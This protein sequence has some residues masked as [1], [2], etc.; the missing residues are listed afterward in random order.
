[1]SKR[2]FLTESEADL[3]IAAAGQVGR[4]GHRD[5]TMLLMTYTHGLRVSELCST[6]WSQIDLNAGNIYVDRIKG[7][8]P[9][10]QPLRSQEI[11]ALRKMRKTNPHAR[12]VFLSERGAPITPRTVQHIVRRAGEKARLDIRVHPHMLRHGCGYRLA[13]RG[14]DTRSIQ[15]YLGHRN[16]QNTTKYTELSPTRFNKFWED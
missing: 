14:I 13:N 12:F 8:V 6:A 16:I 1:M 3:L 4:N 9:S 5:R 10:T 11:R 15:A 2:I 7:G